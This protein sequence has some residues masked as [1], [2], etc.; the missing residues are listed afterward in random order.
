MHIVLKEGGMQMAAIWW[1]TTIGF[2]ICLGLLGGAFVHF[3][4]RGLNPEDSYYI[5]SADD[6]V[7][8]DNI[9]DKDTDKNG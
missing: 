2:I 8:K 1:T 3:L 9:K 7:D 4:K 6:K 5:D